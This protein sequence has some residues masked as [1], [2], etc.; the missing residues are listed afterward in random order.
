MEKKKLKKVDYFL[1]KVVS[2]YKYT[3]SY[4]YISHFLGKKFYLLILQK[5]KN[6]GHFNKN[7]IGYYGIHEVRKI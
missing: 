2:I 5:Y 4:W 1:P 7:L 6:N 3:N